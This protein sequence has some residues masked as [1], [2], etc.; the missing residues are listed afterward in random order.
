MNTYEFDCLAP[1]TFIL[2]M[3]KLGYKVQLINKP[4]F[5]FGRVRVE[6]EP[7]QKFMD[8]LNEFYDPEMMPEDLEVFLVTQ[9]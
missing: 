4:H 7:D 9:K 1:E 8:A 3:A 2:D 5:A 6:A